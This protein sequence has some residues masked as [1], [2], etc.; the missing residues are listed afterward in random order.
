[1]GTMKYEAKFYDYGP[2]GELENVESYFWMPMSIDEVVT[3]SVMRAEAEYLNWRMCEIIDMET[4]EIVR[5][6]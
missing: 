6:I 4:E 5:V 3:E 1:M 2:N